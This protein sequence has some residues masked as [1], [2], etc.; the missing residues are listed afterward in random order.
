[1]STI[2]FEYLADLT[3]CAW[4]FAQAEW[5]Q[6]GQDPI[7]VFE[8]KT[9]ADGKKHGIG[10]KMA[11]MEALPHE[12]VMARVVYEVA[13]YSTV[14]R[15]GEPQMKDIQEALDTLVAR[16]NVAWSAQNKATKH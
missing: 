4:R 3:Q 9:K 10:Y 8:L 16:I 14:L 12:E 1:M 7:L 13:G 2:T 15:L 11:E 6:L 5:P